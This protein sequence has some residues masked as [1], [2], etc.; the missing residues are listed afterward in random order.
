MAYALTYSDKVARIEKNVEERKSATVLDLFSG[1]GSFT[2]AL[3]RN[4]IAVKR[5]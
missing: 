5:V 3:K 4:K 1:I 2:V